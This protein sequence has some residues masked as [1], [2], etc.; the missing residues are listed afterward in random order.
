MAINLPGPE[1]QVVWPKR[2]LEAALTGAVGAGL[3]FAVGTLISLAIPAAIVGGL[4]G[5]LA[6]WRWMYDWRGRGVWAFVLDSTWGL[7]GVAVGLV[8][9]LIN[10]P[11]K[12]AGYRFDLTYRQNHQVY[13]A[14][15]SLRKG[16][17][18][19][20]GN[21][22][23]GAAGSVDFDDEKGSA[24]RRQFIRRHEALHVWQNRW[25]GPFYQIIYVGWLALGA[26]VGLLVGLV[27]R[28]DLRSTIETFAYFNNPFEVWAYHNDEYWPPKDAHQQ[29]VWGAKKSRIE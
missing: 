29:F 18:L 26:V 2:L 27:R 25:F 19:A 16:Y 6:G 9:N 7:F 22:I 14:G 20:M 10:L 15:A 21:V 28:T 5:A 24:Y 8:L 1:Q 12:S 4:N 13:A 23:S 17:A 3:A 11:R